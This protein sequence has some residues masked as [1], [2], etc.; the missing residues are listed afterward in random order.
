MSNTIGVR[1]TINRAV[2][3]KNIIIITVFVISL[4]FLALILRWHSMRANL[5]A[6]S[7]NDL[8]TLGAQN[9]DKYYV[10]FGS[11]NCAICHQMEAIYK[12]ANYNNSRA[13]MY[14]VDLTYESISNPDVLERDIRKVPILV[15]YRADTEISRL[16]GLA[17]YEKVVAFIAQGR[18]D[19]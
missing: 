17:S 18:G 9:N 15:C 7:L 14:Y 19:R 1:E 11:L 12:K 4:F 6:V 10:V 13:K 2:K 3:R 5:I 8:P 16:E